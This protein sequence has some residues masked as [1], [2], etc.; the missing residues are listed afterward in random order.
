MYITG[1]DDRYGA[2]RS[3]QDGLKF[4]SP[5]ELA[6]AIG[7]RGTSISRTFLRHDGGPSG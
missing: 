1:S 6:D 7:Q 3:G 2:C 4:L 5:D